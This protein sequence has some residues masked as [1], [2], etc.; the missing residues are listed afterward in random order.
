MGTPKPQIVHRL[1]GHTHQI[2]A[3]DVVYSGRLSVTE[4]WEKTD[5]IWNSRTGKQLQII[6]VPIPVNR[7]AVIDDEKSI[8]VGAHDNIITIYDLQT[9]QV[10]GKLEG[11]RMGI[12]QTHADFGGVRLLSSS[13]DQS[14]RIRHSRALI[15]LRVL[16]GN[17][18][19]LFGVQFTPDG[20]YAVSGGR[21]GY[22]IV[23]N[24]DTGKPAKSIKAYEQIIL[25]I[26]VLPAGRFALSRSSNETVRIWHLAIGDQ[27][28][29]QADTSGEVKPWLV[30]KLS[31]APMSQKCAHYHSLD[32]NEVR[33][34]GPHFKDLFGRR[35]GAVE[36]YRYSEALKGR[37]FIWN[38]K[39][40]FRLFD[41]GPDKFFPGTKVPVQRVADHNK[42]AQL[43]DYME[44]LTDVTQ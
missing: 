4:G 27:I 35:I 10:Q 23:W 25:S 20:E 37:D 1:V 21:D 14:L 6:K 8:A 34:S 11:H 26:A 16:R 33:R 44:Q 43:V 36:G 18:S 24:L 12:K 30:G 5:R 41:K 19:Q 28:G 17:D 15:P 32:P 40:S 7:G 38:K 2:M 22:I 3:P 29:G 31:G 13:I 39:T 42:L 9:G